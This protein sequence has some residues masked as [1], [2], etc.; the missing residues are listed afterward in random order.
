M[1]SHTARSW[2]DRASALAD[3]LAQRGILSSAVWRTA[4]EQTPRHLFVPASATIAGS[5]TH[6][7]SS[8]TWLDQVYSDLTFVVQRRSRP[9]RVAD[10]LGV[11]F[12][13]SSSTMPVTGQVSGVAS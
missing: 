4:V 13:T 7:S 5:I 10:D 1:R 8:E 2:Q 9:S 12:P 11:A 3:R 6:G